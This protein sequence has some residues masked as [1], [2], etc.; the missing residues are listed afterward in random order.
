MLQY[1]RVI[2]TL[3]AIVALGNP[4]PSLAQRA[5]DPRD[6]LGTWQIMT[7][8]DLTTGAVD[9][10]FKRRTIWT[11]YT[12]THWTYVWMD[13]GRKVTTPQELAALSPAARHDDKYRTMYDVNHQLRFWGSGGSY[14][15]EGNRMH[16]TNLLSIEP[17]QVQLGGVETVTRLDSTSYVYRAVPDRNGVVREFTHRRLDGVRRNTR[18][19]TRGI[20]PE[21]LQGNWQV[22]AVHNLKTGVIDSVWKHQT[23]W[24][25]VTGTHWTYVWQQKD[26]KV[27]TPAQLAVLPPDTRVAAQTAKIWDSEGRNVFWASGG[28]YRI[29]DG[30]FVV[31]P[32]T[33]S[34]APWMVGVSGA[35]PIVRLDSTTYIYRSPPDSAGVVRETIHRRVD[36]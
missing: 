5:L 20:N 30:T 32:R 27:V 14:R 12:R 24:F 34:I 36:W 25:H 13:S 1:S 15:L 21:D 9:S 29:E 19:A 10:L 16:Y 23:M 17:Y 3:F 6:L 31:A 22:V 33:M 2:S 35:E 28:T 11:Q 26:R 4:A 18:T 7:V 8:K